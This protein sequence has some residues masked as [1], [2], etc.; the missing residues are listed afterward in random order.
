MIIKRHVVNVFSSTYYPAVNGLSV[1]VQLN[2]RALLDLGFEVNVFTESGGKPK[3][4][5]NVLTYQI[6]GAGTWI[7]PVNGPDVSRFY[8]D[9]VAHDSAGAVNIIHAWHT[10]TTTLFYK[11]I[12]SIKGSV[13]LYSHGTSF[14]TNIKGIKKVLRDIKYL[15]EK[16]KIVNY[17]SNTNTLITL[18][19]NVTHFR[20]F[21]ARIFNKEKRVVIKNPVNERNQT[22]V[23]RDD[24]TFIAKYA[25]LQEPKV[26]CLSNYE[27]IKNQEFLIRLCLKFNFHLTLVGSKKTK[28]ADG[29]EKM[30]K[31]HNLADRVDVLYDKSDSFIV[32]MFKNSNLFAF[33]SQ[34]D[35]APLVLIEAIKFQLPFISFYTADNEIKGGVFCE[36]QQDYELK[37][38]ELISSEV[39][40]NELAAEGK[41]FYDI[42]HSFEAF[43]ANLLAT[44]SS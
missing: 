19:N 15:G 5:E 12:K 25:L 35:F 37:F 16:K 26:F 20:C 34:N 33:A 29:L 40:I 8:R 22:Q 39:K 6:K 43:K 21:D 14:S 1:V 27:P 11:N 3:Y 31:N 30:V 44:I 23:N 36:S 41:H 7:S 2:V 4:S 9:L 24:D 13:V 18:T 28:Y 17:L 38:E 32:S 42:H 10:W